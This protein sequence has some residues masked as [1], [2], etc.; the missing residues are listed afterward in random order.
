MIMI[1]L[2]LLFSAIMKNSKYQ[3]QRGGN[4]APKDRNSHQLIPPS[5]TRMCRAR[6]NAE[7]SAAKYLNVDYAARRRQRVISQIGL[8]QRMVSGRRLENMERY[9]RWCC[10]QG[11]HSAKL[12]ASLS[13][14]R[15]KIPVWLSC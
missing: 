2:C 1:T 11:N 5:R 6:Y 14:I 3:Y 12:G 9:T 7:A 13:N 4:K 8:S 15:P 10:I